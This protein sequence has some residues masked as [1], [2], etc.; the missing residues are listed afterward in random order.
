MSAVG[1]HVVPLEKLQGALFDVD[2]TLLDTMPQFW[3]SWPEWGKPHGLTMTEDDFY[4]YAGWPVPDILRDIY[5]RQKGYKVDKAFEERLLAEYKVIHARRMKETSPPPRIEAVVAAAKE[6]VAAGVPIVAA[7]SG[8]RET[9]EHHLQV[10]GLG[11]LFPKERIVCA[12]DVGPGRG[13]PKPDIFLRAAEVVGA[14]PRYCIAYED[15]EAGFE[16]AWHAGCQ[17][18]DV[19]DFTGYP[20]P[21]ALRRAMEKQRAKREWLRERSEEQDGG[22]VAKKQRMSEDKLI[23]QDSDFTAAAGKHLLYLHGWGSHN[24]KQSPVY[25]ALQKSLGDAIVQI[26]VPAYHPGGDTSQ[27]RLLNFLEELGN[28]ARS[29]PSGRF[30]AAV[31]HSFGALLVALLQE[32]QPELIGRAVLLAPAI[33]NFERNFAKVSRESWHM[34]SEYVE[35]LRSLP[36]RP[37][38]RVPCVV[39]HGS[40]D[41]DAEGSD[42]WRVREWSND[43]HFHAS[44]F[45]E[46]VNHGLEPWRDSMEKWSEIPQ[47]SE[48]LQWC[49]GNAALPQG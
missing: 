34:P 4:G 14:D 16:A 12:A 21:P 36:A 40:F 8:L 32:K 17:V 48:L 23:E 31:G 27:T 37:A 45:P 3:P 25:L 39:V 5:E 30:D 20:C 49:L 11:D 2:G 35:E 10:A 6:H 7:T 28:I 42:P 19:R 29:L 9:V 22:P 43:Q 1:S 44:Y 47:L 18:V 26:H 24:V 33:D 41:T 46:G 15:A 38:I 13:K